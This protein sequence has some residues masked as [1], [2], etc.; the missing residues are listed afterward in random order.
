MTRDI[1]DLVRGWLAADN[2]EPFEAM[3]SSA[4]REGYRLWGARAGQ[5]KRWAAFPHQPAMS[6]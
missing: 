5:R 6:Q 3:E 4:W 2:G 1:A